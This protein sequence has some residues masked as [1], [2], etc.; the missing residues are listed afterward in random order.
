M[1]H[2][3]YEDNICKK[4][5]IKKLGKRVLI[6]FVSPYWKLTTKLQRKQNCIHFIPIENGNAGIKIY[7]YGY[8]MYIIGKKRHH[9]K[10]KIIIHPDIST[11]STR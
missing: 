5:H 4:C 3:T 6:S 2:I 8:K 7:V 10:Y 1:K 9:D 11:T